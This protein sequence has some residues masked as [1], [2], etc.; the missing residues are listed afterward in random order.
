MGDGAF[1]VKLS[2]AKVDEAARTLLRLQGKLLKPP[3]SRMAPPSF[4]CVLTGV[5]EAAY[6]RP[7]G[8]YVVP[9]CSLGA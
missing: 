3:A 1:E 2:Q 6:Q 4:L 8:V 5:G 9:I 7:D